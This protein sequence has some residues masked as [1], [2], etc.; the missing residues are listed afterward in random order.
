MSS[1]WQLDNERQHCFRQQMTDNSTST[2]PSH[3]HH[4]V[5]TAHIRKRPP[6]YGNDMPTDD[7]NHP[8]TKMK[9]NNEQH[10]LFVIDSRMTC[11]YPPVSPPSITPHH[12]LPSHSLTPSF[13]PPLYYTTPLPPPSLTSPLYYTTPLPPPSL[14]P[15]LYYT[16]PLP[17]HSPPLP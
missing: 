1:T 2:H 14:T 5:T 4:H 7:N 3:H 13:P 11:E 15:P 8:G 12:T 16:T 10:L 6:A 17:P 9:P